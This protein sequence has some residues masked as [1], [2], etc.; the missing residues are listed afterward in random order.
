M[1]FMTQATGREI[2]GV[3]YSL[4]PHYLP[5]VQA[6]LRFDHCCII[7]IEHRNTVMEARLLNRFRDVRLCA[8]HIDRQPPR[9]SS[10]W[11]RPACAGPRSTYSP[12]F[13]AAAP[14]SAR[15]APTLLQ[16][17]LSEVCA[18]LASSSPVSVIS[19]TSFFISRV[20]SKAILI[21]PYLQRPTRMITERAAQH[22]IILVAQQRFAARRPAIF[23]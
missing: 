12:A 13:P 21:A 20:D 6:G 4:T 1:A 8:D 19:A 5:T 18:T 9:P 22:D 11:R 10:A 16:C 2:R 15:A 17:G 23:W 14:V 3:H 7:V